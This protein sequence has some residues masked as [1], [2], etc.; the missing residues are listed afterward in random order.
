MTTG[1]DMGSIIVPGDERLPAKRLSSDTEREIQPADEPRDLQNSEVKQLAR[2]FSRDSHDDLRSKPLFGSNDPDSPLNPSGDNFNARAWATNLARAAAEQG[3]GFRQVGLCFQDIN[4]FGY[5]TPVDFQKTMA[6]IWLA[7]PSMAV[8]HLLPKSSTWGRKR[9]NI[10]NQFNGI[11]RPGEMCA[12]LGPPGSGC[13]T[14][15][16][17]ISGDRNGIYLDEN[18]YLNY[19]G[20]SDRDMHSA[21]RGDAIYT[22]EQDVHFPMLTVNETLTFAARARCQRELPEGISRTQ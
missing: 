15:L 11:I 2:K 10:L 3:Q 5:G 8:R 1:P 17:T 4:V 6:N 22:A 7:A 21:H 13:S 12:V 18:S 19:Q 20:I 14:F 16:K 9:V